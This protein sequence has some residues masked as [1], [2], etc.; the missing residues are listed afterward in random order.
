M[1]TSTIKASITGQ[2]T[3]AIDLGTAALP[4]VASFSDALDSGFAAGQADRLFTDERT[5]IASATEDLDLAGSLVD[6][7]GVVITMV[8]LRAIFIIAAAANTNNVVL[9]RPAANGV[10]L[11]AAVNDAIS[12]QPGGCLLWTAPNGGVTVTPA[13]GDLIT[14][15]N[16]GAGTPVTYKIVLLGTS[17]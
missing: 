1:L 9:S 16:S 8:K 14:L 4:F 17:A 10:P 6:V 11:F 3:S 7:F 5:L 15:T 12:V 2:Q 13:T